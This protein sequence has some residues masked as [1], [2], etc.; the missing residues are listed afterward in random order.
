MGLEEEIQLGFLVLGELSKLY[1]ASSGFEMN[2]EVVIFW[3]LTDGDVVDH[4]AWNISHP[5][6]IYP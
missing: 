5:V 4:P 6:I 3:R 1:P 2:A